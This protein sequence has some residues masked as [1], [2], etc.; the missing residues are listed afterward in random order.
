M[1]VWPTAT[2]GRLTGVDNFTGFNRNH[3]LVF[4]YI[5]AQHKKKSFEGRL[6]GP[7][8]HCSLRLIVLLP[9][10]EFLH[11]TPEAPRTTHARQTSASEGRN[12]YQGIYESTSFFYMKQNWDMGQ[13]LSLP[14][15]RKA[16]WGLFGHPK[17][18]KAS[19]GFE[20]ANS[21]TRGQHANH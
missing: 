11:S 8:Q 13:I 17:N 5:L 1:K 3:P 14:L 20:P 12:Y 15:R 16:C 7:F 21:G 19:A 18:P 2:G 6:V 4:Y 9:P 10:N